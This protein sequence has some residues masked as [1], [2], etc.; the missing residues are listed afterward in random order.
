MQTDAT[1]PSIVG[2]TTL[3]DVACFFLFARSLT[4]DRFQTLRKTS[5][6]QVTKGGFPLSRNFSAR[7]H[8]NFTCVNKIETMYGKSRVYVEVE[9]R[10]TFTLPC[11]PWF[12]QA[13]RYGRNHCSPG[14]FTFTRGLSYISSISFTHKKFTC[15]RTEKFRDS[16][17]QP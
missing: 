17:N 1:A 5:Q 15:V 14:T 3:G 12:L 10:S 11:E 16:G 7:T 6:Q 9:P 4:F 13:G 8:V 2:P